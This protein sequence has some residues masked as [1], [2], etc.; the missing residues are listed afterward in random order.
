MEAADKVAFGEVK[1]LKASFC[2]FVDLLFGLLPVNKLSLAV[3]NQPFALIE[4]VSV[5]LA[6]LQILFLTRDVVPDR[7]HQKQLFTERHLMNLFE[8]CHIRNQTNL[9]RIRNLDWECRSGEGHLAIAPGARTVP[10]SQQAGHHRQRGINRHGPGV[11]GRCDRGTVRAPFLAESSQSGGDFKMRTS[12][13]R[14]R[15]FEGTEADQA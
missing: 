2:G 10:R 4:G 15:L 13:E 12:G 1:D 9:E 8:R 7:L 14:Q 11:G 5:P 3:G 6:Y